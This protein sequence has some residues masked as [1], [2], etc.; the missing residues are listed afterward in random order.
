VG[1]SALVLAAPLAGCGSESSTTGQTG[2]DTD[3]CAELTEF[4]S[5]SNDGVFSLDY[6][7]LA[8]SLADSAPD[9]LESSMVTMRDEIVE[10][11]ELNGSDP[12]AA[13]DAF[14][15]IGPDSAYMEAVGAVFLWG[16]TNCA[17]G[18]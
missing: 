17:S 15:S 12:E 10:I 1:V 3:F 5:T 8:E 16:D 7:A 4:L 11:A 2:D 6:A 13:L 18:G 9:D 14:A